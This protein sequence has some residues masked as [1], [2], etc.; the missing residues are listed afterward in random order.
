MLHMI[1]NLLNHSLRLDQERNNSP[2]R[3]VTGNEILEAIAAALRPAV[4]KSE[5]D[6]ALEPRAN[7]S[8]VQIAF[9]E[10]IG[11]VERLLEHTLRLREQRGKL[12]IRSMQTDGFVTIAIQDSVAAR[13]PVKSVDGFFRLGRPM[14]EKKK[15]GFLA[16][17]RQT[18][19]EQGGEL[20]IDE[21]HAQDTRFELRFPVCSATPDPV[22][23]AARVQPQAI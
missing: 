23:P 7:H 13:A 17:V 1:D 6:L 22:H 11:A 20:F 4:L 15:L 9:D 2:L 19:D 3:R 8:V 16:K 5:V 18:I 14:P 21:Q 12:T 10:V